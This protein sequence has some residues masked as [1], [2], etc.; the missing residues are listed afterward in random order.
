[1]LVCF[2]VRSS[3]VFRNAVGHGGSLSM[4]WFIMT[5]VLLRCAHVHMYDLVRTPALTMTP[6]GAHMTAAQCCSRI[7][8]SV[9]VSY[10]KV[11]SN[12]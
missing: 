4:W 1:M 5:A 9:V 3:G 2:R 11:W 8:W 6:S 7:F 10:V 12:L